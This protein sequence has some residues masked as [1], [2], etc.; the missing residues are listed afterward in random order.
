MHEQLKRRRIEP[1]QILADQEHRAR[2]CLCHQKIYK[3]LQ[4]SAFA[5]CSVMLWG[6]IVRGSGER[7]QRREQRAR[8]AGQVQ[9]HEPRI[10]R[11]RLAA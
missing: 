10:E 2:E 8:V 9:G 11:A 1:L 7:E 6:R 5:S 4:R 3:H